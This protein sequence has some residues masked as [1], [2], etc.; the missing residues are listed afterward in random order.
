MLEDDRGRPIPGVQL[1][2][3]TKNRDGITPSAPISG[4]DGSIEIVIETRLSGQLILVENSGNSTGAPLVLTLG[5]AWYESGFFLTAYNVCDET[6]FRGGK[7]IG[8]GLEEPHRDDFLYSALGVCMEGTGLA[9]NNRYI[10][11]ASGGGGWHLNARGHPD[12]INDPSFVQFRYVTAPQGA[13][14]PILAGKSIAVDHTVIPPG[15]IVAIDGLGERSADDTGGAIKGDHIDVFLG[16]GDSVMHGWNNRENVAVKFL[17]YDRGG[18]V[19][20]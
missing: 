9:D 5:G 7:V 15:A 14:A 16:A 11:Y 2:F 17:R 1:S 8:N 19:V 10:A 6:D 18:N 13:Y 12:R 3:A 20:T 4:A